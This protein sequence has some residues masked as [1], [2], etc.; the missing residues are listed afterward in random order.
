MELLEAGEFMKY[1][2]LT[3]LFVATHS[4]NVEETPRTLPPSQPVAPITSTLFFNI[5]LR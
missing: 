1:Q 4:G 3:K 2:G 5:I